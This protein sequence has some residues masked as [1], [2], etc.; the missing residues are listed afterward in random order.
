MV[1]TSV[2]D[3]LRKKAETVEKPPPGTRESIRMPSPGLHDGSTVST[4]IAYV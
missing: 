4:R 2:R 1:V 3:Y